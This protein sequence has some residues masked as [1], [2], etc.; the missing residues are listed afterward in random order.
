MKHYRLLGILLMLENHGMLTAK[1]MADHFE[2]STRTIYRDLDCLSEAGYSVIT[3]SGKGGGISL[4]HNKRLRVNAMDEQELARLID[5]LSLYDAKDPID[6]NLMLKIRGQLPTDSQ[7]AF[8]KLIT[9]YLVDSRT[10]SGAQQPDNQT[11]TL[12]QRG[13]INNQKLA[14]AYT[15]AN[16]KSSQRVVWPQGIVKKAGSDYLV[17]FCEL[18]SEMRTFK[19]AQ[20][21]NI[22]LIDEFFTQRESFDLRQYW[23]NSMTSLRETRYSNDL[24]P[25]EGHFKYPVHLVSESNLQTFLSGLNVTSLN[26]GSFLCDF[27]SED[28]AVN[29]LFRMA[30]KVKILS[31]VDLRSRLIERAKGIIALQAT[32]Q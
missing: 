18:R 24:K 19:V 16:H 26:D 11:V 3:E 14:F 1:Y 12:I 28:F 32:I 10:W 7:T 8:D 5:K 6:H 31:P 29:Q 17:A 13:I 2:V 9:S 20:I 25:E 22:Q 23:D 21:H 4:G 30:D 15:S 27:I